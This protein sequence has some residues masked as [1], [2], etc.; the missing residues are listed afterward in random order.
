[1]SG[2]RAVLVNSTADELQTEMPLGVLTVATILQQDHGLHAEVH[3]LPATGTSID[4]FVDQLRID[5]R[6]GLVGL[7]TLCSTLPRSLSV[8]RTIKTRHP[9]VPVVL[10]GPQASSV[11]GPLMATYGF[12]DGI[13]IGEAE[14]V[15]SPLWQAIKTSQSVSAAGLVYVPPGAPRGNAVHGGFQAAPVVE[16][17]GIRAIDYR[18]VPRHDDAFDRG[19]SVE[20]GRGCPYRCT[21]CST[22]LFFQRRFRFRDSRAIVAEIQEVI[23]RH[24][25]TRFEFVHDMFTTNRRL[26]QD[27]CGRI[28]DERLNIEWACSARTDRVDDDLLDLMARAGC[29]RI[30]FGVESGSARTQKDIRKGLRIPAV[31]DAV[32]ATW[33]RGI[34]ATVSLIIGFPNE[35]AA[36]LADTL[37]LCFEFSSWRPRLRPVQLHLLSP[38]AATELTSQLESTLEYDGFVSDVAV[39]DSLTQWEESQVRRHPDIFS[40]YYYFPNPHV[41]RSHYRYVYWFVA[42]LGAFGNTIRLLYGRFGDRLGPLLIEWVGREPRTAPATTEEAANSLSSVPVVWDDL[43]RFIDFLGLAPEQARVLDQ[44]AK[45]EYWLWSALAVGPA[46]PLISDLALD[47]LD[48]A[49]LDELMSQPRGSWMYAADPAQKTI[50]CLNVRDLTHHLAGAG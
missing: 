22:K 10:G 12:V 28:I 6:V 16:A 31:R 29:R 27:L 41:P 49:S 15:I 26:V 8:A 38:L 23:R 46:E 14:Q 30:F 35:T 40:S 21:F 18:L 45:Y 20:I 24:G 32:R 50:K 47:R 13:V 19:V 4:E 3:H 11:P 34:N 43:M 17:D 25:S 2:L 9:H 1:M 42:Y 7:S 37:N 5:D 44:V 39:A 36:D 33:Q 48:T